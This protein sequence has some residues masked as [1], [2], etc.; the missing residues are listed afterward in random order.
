MSWS[1][2]KGEKV[3]KG[4]GNY[5]PNFSFLAVAHMLLVKGLFSTTNYSVK[6]QILFN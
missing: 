6:V 5:D 4:R 3:I 1:K 2:G